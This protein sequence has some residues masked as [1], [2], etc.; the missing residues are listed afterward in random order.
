[1]QRPKGYL[2]TIYEYLDLKRFDFY[3][4]LISSG[5]QISEKRSREAAAATITRVHHLHHAW[6]AMVCVETLPSTGGPS[7]GGTR[8]SQ[9]AL[10][11]RTRSNPRDN[12]MCSR[13]SQNLLQRAADKTST[14]M[15]LAP[16]QR[17]LTYAETDG[18]G[19]GGGGGGHIPRPYSSRD[20]PPKGPAPGRPPRPRPRRTAPPRIKRRTFRE[21]LP[22]ALRASRLIDYEMYPHPI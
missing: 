5:S 2:S 19:G 14:C 3:C 17:S 6:L 1:M 21:P 7:T 16:V 9:A 15:A 13:R 12:N 20:R 8:R 10:F 18:A 4:S 11:R 22:S